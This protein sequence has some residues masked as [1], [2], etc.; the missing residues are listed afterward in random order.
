MSALREIQTIFGPEELAILQAAYNDAYR[1][2]GIDGCA[3]DGADPDGAR[4]ALATALL[5][6]A[7]HGER[8]PRALKLQALLA[9]RLS[10]ADADVSR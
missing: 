6:A 7:Q 8:D 9:L 10:P 5:A 3:V 4:S 2:I 1:E